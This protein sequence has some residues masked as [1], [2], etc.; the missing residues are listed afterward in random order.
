[1]NING[2][3]YHYL[4]YGKGSETLLLHGFTGSIE[5]WAEHTAVF[6][7]HYRVIAV[8]LLGHGQTDSPSNARRYRIENAAADLIGL[9]DMLQIEQVTLL[10]Y[11]MGGRLALYTAIQYPERVKRLIL[12]SASPGLKTAEERAARV[13]SDEALAQEIERLGVEAFVHQWEK[14]PLF[15][16]QAALPDAV[17]LRLRELR[18]RNSPI[19][20]ANSLRGMGTG[21]QPSLWDDLHRL[22]MPVL[23]IAGE[24]DQK[25]TLIARLIH[26]QLH[27]ARIAVMPEAGHTLH[28]EQ[29]A[30]FDQMVLDFI[31]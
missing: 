23:L 20:L 27:N 25:F 21:V 7:G 19:G 14:L 5:N 2:V 12:E 8:D 4:D 1:M 17:R 6:A 29:P 22:T 13:V 30:V 15:A 24:A 18:L 16:T 28:L 9:L 31:G 26:Q 3:N 10:G 11:S